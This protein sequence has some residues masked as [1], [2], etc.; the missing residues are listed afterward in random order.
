MQVLWGE[1]CSLLW[2]VGTH[3]TSVV[4]GNFFLWSVLLQ[5]KSTGKDLFQLHPAQTRLRSKSHREQPVLSLWSTRAPST[6]F[7]WGSHPSVIWCRSLAPPPQMWRSWKK[8]T[9][10][11]V[12]N[13]WGRGEISLLSTGV[14]LYRNPLHQWFLTV[15]ILWSFNTGPHVMVT[16]NHK[17]ILLLLPN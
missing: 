14:S 6:Q 16:S 4:K 15:L 3:H 10:S 9:H 11:D 2:A 13:V 12:S 8:F 17:I 5:I 1:A 7:D